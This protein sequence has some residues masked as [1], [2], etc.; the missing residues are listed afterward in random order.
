M[1]SYKLDVMVV[2]NCRVVPWNVHHPVISEYRQNAAQAL[3][4]IEQT[5][6]TRWV[7]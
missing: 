5:N 4:R 6:P 2:W 3:G 7:R 1:Y